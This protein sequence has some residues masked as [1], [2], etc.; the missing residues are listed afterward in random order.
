[1]NRPPFITGDGQLAEVGEVHFNTRLGAPQVLGVMRFEHTSDALRGLVRDLCE[2]AR[3]EAVPMRQLLDISGRSGHSRIGIDIRLGEAFPD[4]SDAAKRID[5]PVKITALNRVLAEPLADLSSLA[6]RTRVDIGRLFIPLSPSLSREEIFEA[7]RNNRLLLPES[8]VVTEDGLVELPL[9]NVRYILSSRLMSVPHNF[10]EMIVK[11][12]HGLGLIQALSPLGLPPAIE[13][14]EFL[15][16]AVRISLGPYTAFIE[17]ILSD[18]RVFHLASRLLDGIRTT[19]INVFRQVELYNM[20][21]EAAPTASL[22]VRLRLYPADEQV[23]RIA[24][25]ILTPAKARCILA[26]GVDFAELSGV[27]DAS[28]CGA[29]F[30]ELSSAPTRG[31]SYG[32]IFMPGKMISIPFENEGASWLTEFQWRLVYEYARGNMR[33]GVL[34]GDE[35]P[36]RLRAF[37]DDL[38]YIGGEQNLSQIFVAHGLPPVDTMR[39][40][41]RNG[42]GVVLAKGVDA[43]DHAGR[44]RLC[45]DQALYEELVKLEGEGMRFYL[46]LG[47][48]QAAHVREFHRGLWVTERGKERLDQAHTTVA[49]FG[50]CVDSLKEPLREDLTGFL[51]R[52]RANPMLGD[53]LAVAHGSGPGVM[54]IVD[55]VAASLDILRLGVGIDAEEIGQESNFAPEAIVQFVNLAMN[56]RQDILDRRS[57]F[58]VFNIGGF[59]TSY[60]I[61]MAL[62]FMKIGQCLPAPYI[63]VDPLGLG[64]NG[65]GLWAKTLEQ[66]VMLTRVNQAKGVTVPP[67]GPKWVLNCCHLAG[68]YLEGLDVIERF[69][70]GPADYWRE[71]EIPRSQVLTAHDNMRKAGVVVPPYI[72]RAIEQA[73]E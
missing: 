3:A 70:A 18:E 73:G 59:G 13:P 41:K 50:S 66:F 29:L 64:D 69:I 14:K 20:G 63:F 42:V 48:G 11:G 61:N 44:P 65:N 7:Q 37:L 15:V 26:R 27:F 4:I 34:A 58:K 19:G 17:R 35:V 68:S 60:E 46:L 54:R 56:T 9:E 39:V 22:K 8:V 23:A 24:A 2:R 21:E 6:K 51:T 71:R 33:E 45:L 62:T 67:L 12:K 31:G 49:M 53:A 25:K 16:G 1:M 40:L 55:D 72:D 5:V 28:V 43:G 36:M 32:R 52:L 38:K 47:E 30:D 57:V 10:S